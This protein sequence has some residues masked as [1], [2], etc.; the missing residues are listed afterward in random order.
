MTI[1]VQESTRELVVPVRG[2]C[3]F[4]ERPAR[5]CRARTV[6]A[7]LTRRGRWAT[8]EPRLVPQDL[9]EL[10]DWLARRASVRLA[11]TARA[12]RQELWAQLV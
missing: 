8:A 10:R 12:A 7:R 1:C 11:P 3:P 6:S 5:A 9:G 2:R 4:G